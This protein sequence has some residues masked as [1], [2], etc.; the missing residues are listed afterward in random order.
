MLYQGTLI[1]VTQQRKMGFSS[2]SGSEKFLNESLLIES[3]NLLDENG[4]FRDF[5]SDSKSLIGTT[6][7]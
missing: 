5:S 2:I 6:A 4:E 3:K 7:T 1:N